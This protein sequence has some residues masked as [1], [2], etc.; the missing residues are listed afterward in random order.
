MTRCY[1]GALVRYADDGRAITV[2]GNAD[3]MTNGSLLKEGDAALAMNLTG[4]RARLIWYSP[5]RVQGDRT[6]GAT[7][8][9]LIPARVGWIVAQLCLVVA[10]LAI[11]QARQLGPSWQSDF[12]WLSGHPRQPRE[13]P[14]LSVAPGPGRAA[15]ALRTATLHR[16]IPAWA[17][18]PMPPMPRSSQR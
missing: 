6:S 16:L 4:D 10:L 1:G 3:F 5:Q 18:A 17:W 12:R 8:G 2:V 9:D 15:A 14:T 13:G 7:I 11:W